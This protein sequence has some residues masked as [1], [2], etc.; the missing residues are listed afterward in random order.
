MIS[1]VSIAL[2]GLTVAT[3]RLDV[4]ASNVANAQD[5]GGL[6]G[7]RGQSAYTPMQVM[8]SD[9]GTGTVAYA[10]PVEPSYTS[11][12]DPQSPHAN[13]QGLVAM[14]NVDLTQELLQMEVAR[15][16][17]EANLKTVETAFSTTNRL[18]GAA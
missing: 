15:Q 4:A 14:P 17:Y 1:P 6:P 18:L 13:S 11:T 10:I 8:Q 9:T 2:S 12:F 5:V 7:A 16:S 3:L